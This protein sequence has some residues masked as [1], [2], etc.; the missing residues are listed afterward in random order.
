MDPFII[1]TLAS[2]VANAAPIIYASIGETLTEKAGVI[3][4]SLDGTILLTAMASFAVAYNTGSVLLGFLCAALIG[5]LIAGIVALASIELE[6]EQVAVGFVLTLLAADLSSFLGN[7]YVNL[8][9]P[10]LQQQPFPLLNRLPIVGDIFFNHN[11]AI[12]GS[13][14]VILAAWWWMAKTQPGLRMR[15]VGERPESAFA[16]GVNVFGVRYAYTLLGGALVGI[17][18]ATYSLVVKLGWS[19]NHTTGN[20]WIAL[21]IVIFGGWDPWKVAGGAYLFGALRALG[22]ALQRNPAF[23]NVPTQI[24]ATAPFALMI[25]FLALTSSGLTDRFLE[26][27]SPGTQRRLERLI[28]GRGPAALGKPFQRD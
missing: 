16:R 28:R 11:L 15:G 8:A 24:F 22:S 1:S 18:G 5:A 13:F 21:A 23:V 7:P 3:N 17:G 6:Q 27:F 4:L 12:Y 19:H 10:Y 2:I 25:L 9:G 20:G 26:L 14:A